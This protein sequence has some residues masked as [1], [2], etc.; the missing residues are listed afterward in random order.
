MLFSMLHPLDE[1]APVISRT[2][3][4]TSLSKVDFVTESSQKLV[5]TCEDPSLVMTYDRVLGVHAV[6][7]LRRAKPDVICYKIS[8]ARLLSRQIANIVFV[9]WYSYKA[10]HKKL[11]VLDYSSNKRLIRNILEYLCFK[12]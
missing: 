2:G 8:Y 1:V 3:G 10:G 6:W 9:M 12:F 4:N 5:F 11:S 7:T